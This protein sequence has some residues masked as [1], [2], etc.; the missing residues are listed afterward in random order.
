[1]DRFTN[2]LLDKPKVI[3]TDLLSQNEDEEERKKEEEESAKKQ[4]NKSKYDFKD[5]MDKAYKTN[6]LH[7]VIRFMTDYL[8][9]VIENGS[10][11]TSGHFFI[12]LLQLSAKEVENQC[13]EYLKIFI[14]E[15][16]VPNEQFTKFVAGLRDESLKEAYSNIQPYLFG[17]ESQ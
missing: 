5:E 14:D 11:Y 10:R 4:E 7:N 1:M 2:Q 16:K 8:R 3:T 6:Q 12:M 15:I 13:K 9:Q 17:E